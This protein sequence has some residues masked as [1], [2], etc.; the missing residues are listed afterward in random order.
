[1][2]PVTVRL[3]NNQTD[4]HITQRLSGLSWRTAVPGGYA[5][6]SF[7]LHRPITVNDP[8]LAP[9]TKTY[10]YDGRN[11]NVLWEGR[12]ALPG[13][14]VGE[15]GEVWS[16]V[17][18]GPASHALDESSP[19]IYI[20]RRLDA[21]RR[22]NLEG[23]TMPAMAS[24]SVS[25]HPHT[26]QF[27]CVICQSVGGT[28]VVDGTKIA[29]LYETF[30][31]SGMEVGAVGF[32]WDAGFSSAQWNVE[33]VVGTYPGYASIP[34]QAAANTSGG[35]ITRWVIDDFA[36]GMTAVGVRIVR[37]SGGAQTTAGDTTWG[38]FAD[39]RV[40]GRRMLADGT[41]VSG[42]AG[43]GSSSVYVRASWVVEDLLGRML[44][45]YNG[46]E[47]VI[48]GDTVDIDQ[49]VYEDPAS[50]NQVLEDLMAL[51]P[52]TFWAAWEGDPFTGKYRFEW[53]TWPTTVRYEASANDGFNSPSPTFELYDAVK[54]RWRDSK[55]KVKWTTLTQSV[56]AMDEM[57][58]S[59]EG[60]V[61]LGDE[62]GSAANAI[63][64]GNKFL[65]DHKDPL[66]SGTLVLSRPIYDYAT[67]RKVMPWEVLPGT[68]LRL[69]GVEAS[70]Q[71]DDDTRDGRTIFRI[72]A[73]EPD[74]EGSAK[75]ELD[76]FPQSEQRT[77][78]WLTK[79]RFRRQ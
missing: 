66:S 74:G 63:A 11:G 21:W 9:F 73:V 59:R 79:K 8:L 39:L 38:T 24:V 60:Y 52:G 33:M 36:G 22:S 58:L 10:I 35:V 32:S 62:A 30:V 16:L 34:F 64:V 68:L 19:L 14:E 70:R 69:R 42:G 44:P 12:L 47:A 54:V 45:Q 75:L 18:S 41:L 2:I 56:P 65:I 27:D 37:V 20:D 50:A 78:A 25:N 15:G 61:D 43:M 3:A 40:L 26:S 31:G 76:M 28:P 55:G 57:N 53:S 5:S 77:L 17:A 23:S 51:E 48:T 72:V 6:A 7:S 4:Q 13:K 29:A 71:L 46:T 1:M 67:N 49:L